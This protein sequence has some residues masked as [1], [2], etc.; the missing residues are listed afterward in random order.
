VTALTLPVV[1]SGLLLGAADEGER[2]LRV[3]LSRNPD[4][5]ERAVAAIRE[6]VAGAVPA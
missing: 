5:V 6:V 3:A 1:P 2:Y 4:E